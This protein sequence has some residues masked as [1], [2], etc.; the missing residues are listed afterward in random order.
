MSGLGAHVQSRI[1]DFL[2]IFLVE[3]WLCKQFGL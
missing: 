3:G 1:L 2:L